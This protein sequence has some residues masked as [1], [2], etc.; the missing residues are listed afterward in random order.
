MKK[1]YRLQKTWEFDVVIK[2]K[3]QV[4]NS[5]LVIYY[6]PAK[7]FKVGITIPKKF[8]NAVLRNYY[9][10]QLKAIVHELNVYDMNYH[11]VMII[12][13]DFLDA[14]YESKLENTRKLMKKIKN[15]R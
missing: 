10:R 15:E 3:K 9:K 1:E 14:S 2:N 6:M 7:E 4:L 12:R 8:C 13:K 5:L 11:F